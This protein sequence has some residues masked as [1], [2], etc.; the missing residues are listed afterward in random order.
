MHKSIVKKTFKSFSTKTSGFK[1]KYYAYISGKEYIP[2]KE[3][4]QYFSVASPAT[5]A[6]LCE[7][8][9]CDKDTVNIAIQDANTTFESGVWSRS[10]VRIR[11]KILNDIAANLR[12]NIPRLA[13]ME[14]AQTGRAVREM[15]AQLAR[16]PEW[17]EYF[18]ALIRTHEGTVP[19]FLGN[20]V[21]YVKR[22]PLGVCGLITPW[23]HPM[24]IAIKK[25]APAIAAG[26]CVVVKPSELAPVTVIELAKL[27]TESGLPNGVFNVIP[28]G[29]EAGAT[30][31][32][33]KF[34]KKIDLTGGTS[35]GRIV[36]A[37]AGANLASVVSELGGKAPMII[38]P[39]CD[40]EQAV[41]SAAF[42]T[43]VASGQTCIMGAR[44][45]IHKSIYDIFMKSIADKAKTIKLGDP[46]SMNTQMGPV[47]SKKSK[48]RITGMVNEAVQ[49][50]A[51]V[52]AGG[53]QPLNMIKPF[54][55]GYYYEPTVLNVTTKMDI[56]KEE[57]FGPVVV[58][59]PFENEQEAISLANDSPY[60]LAAA[61]WTNDVMR[62]HRVADKLDVGIIWINDHHRN[63]PSSPWGGMK[64]SGI[65][66]ENGLSAFHEYTQTKSI[67]V[68]TDPSP[69]DWFEQKDA[70]YS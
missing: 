63:D 7:V 34:I 41:N 58:G 2:S 39:D 36:G 38:F 1:D 50:G 30:L 40:L 43:F 28:G 45:I 18:S 27:C 57:V 26:N 15:K 61:I 64:D 60:G 49:Q 69:F 13:E 56:W 6:K 25:I 10:D 52:L 11:G 55:L 44:L 53:K 48:E 37:A 20:Y 70:R 3:N 59:V 47:I 54:D 24:L 46:M 67:I 32:S 29:I 4:I 42:A 8:V 17:F 5:T 12:E 33:N 31:C 23:N 14:V 35:T 19:P 65:G 16:L 66:R 68:R 51:T 21:N 22:V 9:E 62:A